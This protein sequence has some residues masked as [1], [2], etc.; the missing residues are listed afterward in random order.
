MPGIW[1]CIH[2]CGGLLGANRF[3]IPLGAV[4]GIGLAGL[5]GGAN[6]FGMGV[7]LEEDCGLIVGFEGGGIS[8]VSLSLAFQ[9]SM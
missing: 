6:G 7:G 8:F 5:G 1:A 9:V 2:G 4:D 3:G